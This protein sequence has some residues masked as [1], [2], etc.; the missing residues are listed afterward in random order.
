MF[1]FHKANTSNLKPIVHCDAK[2]FTLGPGVG[3]DPQR[4]NFALGIQ[5][6]QYLKT[7]K[8]V[9]PPTP[10][11]NASRCNIGG[12]GSPMQGAGVGNVLFFFCLLVSFALGSQR[13]PSFQWD[14][15]FKPLI[16]HM[17][18]E[19]IKSERKSVLMV[20]TILTHQRLFLAEFTSL[21]KPQILMLVSNIIPSMNL[22]YYTYPTCC[23]H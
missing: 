7:L 22:L 19:S 10:T 18:T 13:E 3:S 14:M 9:L 17:F 6:C 23:Q 4:H 15:G 21:M 1:F 12:V 5:T 16:C 20:F 11:S 2:P 8:F